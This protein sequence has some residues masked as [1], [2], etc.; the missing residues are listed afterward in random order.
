MEK[1]IMLA[2]ICLGFFAMVVLT[3]YFIMKFRS[4]ASEKSYVQEKRESWDWQKPGVVVLGVG[5]G[6]VIVGVLKSV[7]YVYIHGAAYIGIIVIFTGIAM[8]IAQTL[9]K[10]KSNEE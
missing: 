4:I 8:I 7:K 6:A 10:R 1:E 3:V 2:V 9:D 5:V